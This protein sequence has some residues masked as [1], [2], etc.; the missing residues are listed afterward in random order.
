MEEDDEHHML[1]TINSVRKI[2]KDC[3][4][5]IKLWV[6]YYNINYQMKLLQ[7]IFSYNGMYVSKKSNVSIHEALQ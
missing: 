1:G 3:G 7:I 6:C 2:F 5:D 4:N